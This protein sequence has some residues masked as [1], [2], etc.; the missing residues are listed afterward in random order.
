ME[1]NAV[2]ATAGFDQ[3]LASWA[4][5]AAD[6]VSEFQVGE[7]KAQL[8][9]TATYDSPF[10]RTVDL[11][12][13]PNTRDDL[14]NAS[15]GAKLRIVENLNAVTNIMIPLNRGGMRPNTQLTLGAEYSF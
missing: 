12:T 15:F 4:T 2:L 6:I 1:N 5:V 11:T 8:P 9:T 14:I 13:I 10:V 7:N 3:V